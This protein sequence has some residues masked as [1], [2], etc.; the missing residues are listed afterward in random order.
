MLQPLIASLKAL[1]LLD[2]ISIWIKPVGS[3][4]Y[5]NKWLLFNSKRKSGCRR[6]H[7][8][9]VIVSDMI[10]ALVL[11]NTIHLG[12]GQENH[13]RSQNRTTP[14]GFLAPVPSTQ[15]LERHTGSAKKSFINLS[16]LNTGNAEKNI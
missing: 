6:S 2:F 15:H 12:R 8:E 1:S 11:A 4:P 16:M 9:D 13:T 10:F 7:Q 3:A 14:K 5:S